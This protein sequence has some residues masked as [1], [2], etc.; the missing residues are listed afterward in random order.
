MYRTI[1]SGKVWIDV[2]RNRTKDGHFFWVDATIVPFMG[3]DQKPR[4]YISIQSDITE[5]KQ[6]EQALR[7]SQ[8]MEAIGQLTGGIAHDFNNILHIILG[9]LE[10]LDVQLP[11]D[12]KIQQRVQEIHKSTQRAADLTGQLLSFSRHQAE[13]ETIASINQLIEE[14]ENLIAHSITPQVDIEYDL[15]EDLWPTAISPGDFNDCFLN[16]VINARDAMS[17]SGLLNIETMNTRLDIH[18]C[19]KNPEIKPGDYV[20]LSISDSGE[21]MTA[22]QLEHIFEPFYTTKEQGKGTGLGLSMVFGFIQRSKGHIKVDSKQGDGT[23]FRLYLPRA[24]ETIQAAN[25]PGEQPAEKL[26]AGNETILLVDDE[27]SLRKL[28]EEILAGLGYRVLTAANGQQALAILA[29]EPEIDLLLSDVI[30]PGGLNG[31]E[32]AERATTDH[33]GLKVLLASGHTKMSTSN[34]KHNRFSTTLLAKP[35][36]QAELAQ[37]VREAI[38]A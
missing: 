22:E 33:P 26:P 36:S 1:T 5:R 23:T 2:I 4:S 9:N 27:E 30:M 38:T 19:E 28:V 7:R 32:L 25:T 21:G 31:Y 35:Y 34:K 6:A 11:N 13:N 37:K 29:K 10:L 17:G 24:N 20:Q 8:K 12:K 15:A 3:N 16:L 18:Y 14:M